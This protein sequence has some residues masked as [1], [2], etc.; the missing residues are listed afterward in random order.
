MR[1]E[2]VQLEQQRE[3]LGRWAA[4]Y[5]LGGVFDS[6]EFSNNLTVTPRRLELEPG[7]QVHPELG[8]RMEIGSEPERRVYGDARLLLGNTLHA[9][10][11]H[12][13]ACGKRV[14]LQAKG[15]QELLAEHLAR[16][17][18]GQL[19]HGALPLSDNR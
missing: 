7:L 6:I 9:R 11:R 14:G 1:A 10:A 19:G 18:R 17:H 8:R 15:L 16:M 12:A 3:R 5:G 13:Y 2:A 4:E